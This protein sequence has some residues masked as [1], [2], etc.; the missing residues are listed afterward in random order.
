M[1][2][3][4]EKGL[5]DF[6]QNETLLSKT[7]EHKTTSLGAG[8]KENAVRRASVKLKIETKITLRG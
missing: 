2:S 3:R 4:L 6:A 7:A 1:K 8:T 5:K